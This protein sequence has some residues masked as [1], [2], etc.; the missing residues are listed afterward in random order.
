MYYKSGVLFL[1]KLCN[2]KFRIILYI[3]EEI[4]LYKFIYMDNLVCILCNYFPIFINMT[5]L[6]KNN[7]K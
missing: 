7:K 6:T 1:E 3:S 5:I 4:F 2:Y